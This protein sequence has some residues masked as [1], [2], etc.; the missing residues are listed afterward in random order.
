MDKIPNLQQRNKFEYLHGM[1]QGEILFQV[2]M[3]V[4]L[5]PSQNSGSCPKRKAF[6][7]KF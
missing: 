2:V 3:K 6:C 4:V 1:R 7:R 5:T